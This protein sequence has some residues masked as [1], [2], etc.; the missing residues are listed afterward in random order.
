M[1]IPLTNVNGSCTIQDVCVMISASVVQHNCDA[2]NLGR[3]EVCQES[4]PR[5]NSHNESK[6]TVSVL[7]LS[8]VQLGVDGFQH[9][10]VWM[11]DI[12]LDG[13]TIEEFQLCDF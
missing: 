9:E 10:A 6:Y 13:T 3:K 12:I 1:E 4:I 11:S 7:H 5:K 2:L 8:M